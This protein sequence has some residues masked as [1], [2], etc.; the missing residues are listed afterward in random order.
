MNTLKAEVVVP[1][2]VNWMAA[3]KSGQVWAYRNKPYISR[4]DNYWSCNGRNERIYNGKPPKNF[5]DELYT[6][7]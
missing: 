6:W 4:H 3:D 1:D 5:R 7:K 2:W